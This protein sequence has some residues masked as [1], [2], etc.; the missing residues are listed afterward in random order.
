MGKVYQGAH[1]LTGRIAAVKVVLPK[2]EVERRMFLRFQ[3]E[4]SI[5][6]NLQ[7]PNLVR[8]YETSLEDDRTYFVSEFV[9]G[10]DLCQYISHRGKPLLEVKQAVRIIAQSLEG[11]DYFHNQAHKYVHRDLKP[12]NILIQKNRMG[13]TAKLA[14]FGLARSYEKHGGTVTRTK[15][16]A[17]TWFY[18]PPEQIADF[19][20]C[21]PPADIYS[22]GVTLFYLLTA[23]L[24]L[25]LPAPWKVKQGRARRIERPLQVVIMNDDRIPIRERRSD[26]PRKLAQV[27][28]KSTQ[29]EVRKRYQT[30][31]AFRH[32]LLAAIK[33]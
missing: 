22:M 24:P 28:D 26:I 30:A 19:K 5:M 20:G 13:F 17:G 4:I 14:D 33:P 10:G 7:H 21:K 11:L 12:E 8:L 31:D 1:K 18:M 29:R 27:V 6:R 9:A 23:Q 3:R 25:D 15:E 32:D 16:Y 2:V